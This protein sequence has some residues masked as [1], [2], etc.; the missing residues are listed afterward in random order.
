MLS[1]YTSAKSSSVMNPKKAGNTNVTY[2]MTD[3]PATSTDLMIQQLGKRVQ[4]FNKMGKGIQVNMQPITGSDYYTKLN[5]MAAANKLPDMVSTCGGGKMK[6]YV[7]SSKYRNL[8]PYLNADKNWKKSFKK[9]MFSLCTFNGKTY[10]IPINYSASCVFYNTQLFKK[11]GIKKAPATWD[12]FLSDCKMLK[13][14]GITP[15][16]LSGKDGWC[17]AVFSAYLSNRIGGNAPFNAILSGGGSWTNKCFI[18]SGEMIRQ[19]YNLGYTQKSC[20]GDN[21]DNAMSYVKSGKAAMIVMGSWAIAQLETSDSQVKGKMGVFT[22]PT[23]KG[24]KGDANAWLAKTDNI[25]VSATSSHPD[26]CIKFIKY[27]TSDKAQKATAEIAGKIPVTNVKID[28]KK[29]PK[30]FDYL[31][32]CMKNTSD[33]FNF[34]DEA[35]GSVIGDEYDST[36]ST[37]MAGTKTPKA[38]FTSLQE[39]TKSNR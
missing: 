38:A 4:E 10:G 8:S 5:A 24:G 21:A 16:A 34:Y 14:A 18:K 3:D 6:T 2:V 9:G 19:L 28:T 22:F 7:T 32:K 37:I 23:V 39:Y 26:A 20:I 25:A 11:A 33:V 15:I 1:G 12:A 30:E 13:K 27:L 17:V 31:S 35:L 36:M 29:A